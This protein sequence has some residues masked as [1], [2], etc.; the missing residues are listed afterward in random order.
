[1]LTFRKKET[2]DAYDKWRVERKEKGDFY[3]CIFCKL[4]VIVKDFKYW[5]ISENDFPYDK[6]FRVSHLLSP[7]RHVNEYEQLTIAE[8]KEY[9]L[10]REYINGTY[11][12]VLEN[13]GETKTIYHYHLHLLTYKDRDEEGNKL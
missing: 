13:F 7:I 8:I 6:Y 3:S 11:N 1:M 10:I 9:Y 2:D 12:V 5:V 4:N